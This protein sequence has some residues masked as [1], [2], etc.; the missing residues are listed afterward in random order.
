MQGMQIGR[1]DFDPF[2]PFLSPPL[3]VPPFLSLSFPFCP[4]M[5]SLVYTYIL[6]VCIGIYMMFLLTW[7]PS[8]IFGTGL[9]TI[10]LCG[11]NGN[12]RPGA[13]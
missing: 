1:V 3:S 9:S 7:S 4:F 8:Y 12:D 13:K 2:A 11:W 6:A 10:M 5:I